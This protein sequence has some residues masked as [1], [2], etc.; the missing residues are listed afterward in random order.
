MVANLEILIPFIPFLFSSILYTTVT[1][2]VFIFLCVEI[3]KMEV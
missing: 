2:I 1:I 3:A